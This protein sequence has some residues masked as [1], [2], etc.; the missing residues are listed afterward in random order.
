MLDNFTLISLSAAIEPLRMA[1]RVLRQD[2][3]F[4]TTLS[5]DG[6]GV[7]A[8]D[9]LEVSVDRSISDDESVA[10]LDVVIVCGGVRV[11]QNCHPDLLRWLRRVAQRGLGMGAVCT[12]ATVLATAGVLDGYQCSVHWENVATLREAF[13]QVRVRGGVFSI[14]RNRYTSS[15]GTA[16]ID[17]MLHFI[18]QQHS[19]E[20]SAAIAD[21]FLCERIRH[22]DDKQ[23]VP[24]QH[25]LGHRSQKL[26]AAVE[27][28]EA[29][30]KEPIKQKELA[31]YVGLSRRQ[32][33][34]LFRK[35]LASTPS[36]YYLKLRL[37][38][39]R[40]L[41]QQSGLSILE[42]SSVCGFMSSSHFSKSYKEHFGYSPSQEG[43]AKHL[44]VK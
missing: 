42:I 24:L 22:P 13:P 38:R 39:A 37:E 9:G 35:H 25:L 10:D 34:R 2:S 19:L 28:M 3:Y 44:G 43:N 4:W 7:R 40:K 16:P 6:Q 41:L 20:V 15:G 26:I 32:L 1:N 11:E 29:N 30:L 21:Q 8:S 27:L 14:D 33:E 12:G 17:M 5:A 23:R 36:R 18:S 31:D